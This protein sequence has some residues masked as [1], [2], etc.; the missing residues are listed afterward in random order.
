MHATWLQQAHEIE[1]MANAATTDA[2]LE[3]LCDRRLELHRRIA[4]TRAVSVNGIVAQLMMAHMAM[5][6][7]TPEDEL[8]RTAIESAMAALLAPGSLPRC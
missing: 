3:E 6:G 7:I 2:E 5:G 8:V 1:A 4:T